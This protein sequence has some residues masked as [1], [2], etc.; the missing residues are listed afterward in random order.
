M[1]GLILP[2]DLLERS[3]A[4]RPREFVSV[5]YDRNDNSV[6]VTN[7]AVADWKRGTSVNALNSDLITELA[8]MCDHN[9]VCFLPSAYEI[10]HQVLTLRAIW[11]EKYTWRKPDVVMKIG[12]DY[13][14]VQSSIS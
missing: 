7:H 14:D 13:K 9:I 6:S 3:N 4:V 5:G 8:E 11:K 2:D 10:K 12:E 1:I